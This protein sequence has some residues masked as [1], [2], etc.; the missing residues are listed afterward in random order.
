MSGESSRA[1]TAW[2]KDVTP[3]QQVKEKLELHAK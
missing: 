3:L 2:G 1:D